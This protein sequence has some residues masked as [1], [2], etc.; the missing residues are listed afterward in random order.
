MF[1]FHS[2]VLPQ[3][4]SAPTEYSPEGVSL[5]VIVAVLCCD[6][7]EAKE[8]MFNVVCDSS[9]RLIRRALWKEVAS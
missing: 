5:N 4:L 9:R 7:S 2:V 8:W 1:T 3:T 6:Q